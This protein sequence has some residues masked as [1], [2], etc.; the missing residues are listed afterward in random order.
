M[1]YALESMLTIRTMREDR[2]ATDLAGAR[3]AKSVAE[4]VVE[5]KA[6]ARATFESTRDARRDRLYETVMGRAVSMDD[7]DRIRD[8]VTSIDEE[9]VL[10]EA[11]EN[12]AKAELEKRDQTARA[13]K[14]RLTVAAKNKAKIQQHRLAWEEEDRR[15]QE[16]LADAEMEEFT[17]RRMVSD[18]DDSFD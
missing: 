5:E 9:G 6:A 2:A 11:A 4:R 3:R 10:L 17:G 14:V 13:A 1:A 7:L 15:T 8:A 16:L 12:Q 18:D